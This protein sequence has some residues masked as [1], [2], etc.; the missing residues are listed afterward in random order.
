MVKSV[1]FIRDHRFFLPVGDEHYIGK[2]ETIDN[3]NKND[4]IANGEFDLLHG[5]Q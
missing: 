1:I 2:P 5:L 3:D 4:K